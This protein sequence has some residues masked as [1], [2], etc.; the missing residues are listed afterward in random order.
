MKPSSELRE[1]GMNRRIERRDFLNGMAIGIG[2]AYAALRG[3]PARAQQMTALSD[4]YPPARLGLR[5]QHPGAVEALGRIRQGG[6]ETFP[7]IDVDTRETYDL[8]IV[9]G[10]LSGLA[11][12]YFWHNALPNQRVL[13]LDNHDDFG[14]H[15]KRNEFRYNGRTFLSYGGTM[16]SDAVP[17]QLHGQGAARRSRDRRAAEHRIR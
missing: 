5:G 16:S 3:V 13:V 9:G 15:A 6:F 8:V 14:G 7:S 1:L 10:G 11:A 12:A 17:L 4:A 2:S